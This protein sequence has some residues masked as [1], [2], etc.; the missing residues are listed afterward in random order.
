[1]PWNAVNQNYL[2][3][4]SCTINQLIKPPVF[5]LKFKWYRNDFIDKIYF[6]RLKLPIFVNRSNFRPIF[7]LANN[8]FS[9]VPRDHCIIFLDSDFNFAIALHN[10]YDP[11]FTYFQIKWDRTLSIVLGCICLLLSLLA[12][13]GNLASL[14]YVKLNWNVGPKVSF[15]NV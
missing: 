12:S 9:P 11:G 15:S 3:F 1:M 2:H 6:H 5:L 7:V 13:A 10:H 4:I 14:V 8:L